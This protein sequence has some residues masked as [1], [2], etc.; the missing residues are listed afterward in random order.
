MLAWV[1]QNWG[2]IVILG[3]IALILSLIVL[4]HVRKKR[5]GESTCG[6]GCTQCAMKGI[7]HSE[8]KS[9]ENAD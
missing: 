2:N 9:G 4:S 8:K 3:V 7:C 5:R 1:Q 6:C